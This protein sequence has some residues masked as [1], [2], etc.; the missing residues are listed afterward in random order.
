MLK[1]KNDKERIAFLDERREEDG[2]YIWSENNDTNT[3]YVRYDLPEAALIYFEEVR[4]Y[5]WPETHITWSPIHWYVVKNW[6]EPFGDSVASRTQALQEL[7]REE[8]LQE[9]R[10]D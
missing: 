3:R 4:T 6:K 9:E 8:K 7:K 5:H 2:W 10:D 1:F